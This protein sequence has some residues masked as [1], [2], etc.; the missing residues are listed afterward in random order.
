M[1]NPVNLKPFKH[2]CITIGNL[3]T[4]YVDSL[5]Y[6]EMLEWL[7]HYLKD[8]VI[9]AVNTNADAV[10][11]LQGLYVEL[12]NYVDNYFEN[13]DVQ[14][15]INNKLDD[16]AESGELTEIIAQYLSL[17]GILAF[18]TVSDMK[19]ATNLINGSFTRTLGYYSVNDGG[20]AL[21][22]IRSITNS[23]VIDESSIISIGNGDLIAELINKEI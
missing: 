23:D 22:K 12:K 21:Y 16:M 15:E 10:T 5:S 9:P 2:F 14:E 11:E 8:T 20:D 17:A 7:C 6:Y 1:I 19:S 3:P 13:L 4:S 18:N